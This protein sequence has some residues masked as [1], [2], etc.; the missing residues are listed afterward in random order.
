[1]NETQFSLWQGRTIEE[2]FVAFHARHPEVYAALVRLA[3]DAK[4]A[5]RRKLGIRTLWE[6]LRWEM[7]VE[8]GDNDFALNDHFT[9]RYVRKLTAEY[10]DLTGF[11]ET[12]GLR[13][14]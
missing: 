14:V 12:R 6:R 8:K 3:L 5:G 13:A 7:H 10:P 9:S 2:R 4:A 1:M 11:F